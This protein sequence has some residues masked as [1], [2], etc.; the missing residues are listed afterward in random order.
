MFKFNDGE[1]LCIKKFTNNNGQNVTQCETYSLGVGGRKEIMII[2]GNMGRVGEKIYLQ[3]AGNQ[4][5]IDGYICLNVDRYRILISIDEQSTDDIEI[6]ESFNINIVRRNPNNVR[7]KI[8]LEF[9]LE[10]S[11]T[12]I[13]SYEET[14]LPVIEQLTNEITY[15]AIDGLTGIN[16]TC[17]QSDKDPDFDKSKLDFTL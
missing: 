7:V 9:M 13:K 2:C 10:L 8:G 4:N 14:I 16:R 5:Y 12:K 6:D 15:A 3:L 17:W 11:E 1:R